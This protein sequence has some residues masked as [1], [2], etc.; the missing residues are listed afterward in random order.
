[1]DFPMN[2]TDGMAQVQQNLIGGTW[3]PA[4]DGRTITVSSPSDGIPF[5]AIPD[6]SSADVD[7]AV[8]AARAKF[9]SPEWSRLSAADRGRLLMRLADLA[10]ASSE[11]LT[12]L[13]ARDTGKPLTQARAD[14]A[15]AVRY[16]EFYGGGADKLHGEVIPFMD[17]FHAQAVR[18]PLGV[19][20]HITPWNYPAQMFGRT[21]SP[22][23]AA[24]NTVVLKP[25]ED[26]CMTPIA[27]AKL[28]EEAGFPKGV[29]NVVSGRGESAGGCLA[30]HPGIDFISFT[31]S[32]EAGASVQAATA[33]SHVGCTLE[34]GGKSPQI[35]FADA[36]FDAAMPVIVKAITQNSGQTCSAG[37]RALIEA[38]V[39]DKVMADLAGRF[40]RLVAAPHGEDKDLGALI[41][42][43][44]LRR[45]ETYVSDSGIGAVSR[46]EI[47]GSAPSGGHYFAPALLG[48]VAPDAEIA[49]E[50]VFGPVL[51]C[52]PFKDEED[53]VRLAN[54][55]KYGLVAGVWTADGSR[56]V[57]MSKAVRCGQLFINCFGAGGGIELPFGGVGKSGHGRE[58]GFEALREFTQTKT[59]VQKYR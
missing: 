13:E 27:L 19:T 58:K 56:Q 1:M 21:L 54:A 4:L 23:L 57:R 20:A 11:S 55:T 14:I 24:G 59:V 42:S 52:I 32:P 3:R 46:G 45:V 6:S 2:L 7:A 53:A 41:S 25:A 9:E 43:K 5:A 18:E 34:L 17:G 33:R 49:R 26:A 51:S 35:V 38:S 16:F 29:I 31:G 8:A 28:A 10:D 47:S 30:A 37:S 48:P 39:F 40:G 36:D 44:Q 22:S 15:A 50:E 12:W